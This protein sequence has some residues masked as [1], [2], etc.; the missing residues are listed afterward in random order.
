M[1]AILLSV[2][3]PQQ[4]LLLLRCKPREWPCSRYHTV[5]LAGKTSRLHMHL[6]RA[7][8]HTHRY[9]RYLE[10]Q[11][12]D[13]PHESLVLQDNQLGSIGFKA[14]HSSTIGKSR[15][16]QCTCWNANM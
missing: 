5:L 7:G 13:S 9:T 14:L 11:A 3:L 16:C 6:M 10:T 15:Q 12:A 1:S 2:V 8:H 4:L